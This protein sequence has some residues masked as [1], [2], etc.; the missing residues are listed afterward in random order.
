MSIFGLVPRAEAVKKAEVAL[1]AY[2][3]RAA[4]YFHYICEHCEHRFSESRPNEL[5]KAF[6][7][8]S[9]GKPSKAKKVGYIVMIE[10][11]EPP[12]TNPK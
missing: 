12:K 3:G 9:C 11:S 1:K 5:A 7:C 10:A 2:K 6:T 4:V 8:P